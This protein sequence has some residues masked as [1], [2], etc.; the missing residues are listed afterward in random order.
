MTNTYDSSHKYRMQRAS[1]DSG[2]VPWVGPAN[3][4][5]LCNATG[6]TQP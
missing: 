6:D 4:W 1:L 2:S 5:S 3:L